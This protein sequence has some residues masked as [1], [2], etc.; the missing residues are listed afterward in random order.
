MIGRHNVM[1]ALAA[2]GSGE[3]V[4]H[5]RGGSARSISALAPADK[6]GE[7]V[8]FESGFTVI[9]DCYN[10]SPTA[11]DALAQ[12]LA[13]TPGYRRRILAAGEMLE[14][15]TGSAEL[16]RECGQLAAVAEGD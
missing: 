1:N 2:F 9:N 6:R 15:G 13:E 11:L 7:V 5:R 12:L 3:R 16:H 10:S 14:L 4:G 8:R